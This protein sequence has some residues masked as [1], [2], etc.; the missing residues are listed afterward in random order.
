MKKVYMVMVADCYGDNNW[1]PDYV[2]I[3]ASKE[4]ADRH[5]E[6]LHAMHNP[7]KHSITVQPVNYVE[8]V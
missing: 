5:A 3:F 6:E 2:R 7:M 8:E 1:L 4:D